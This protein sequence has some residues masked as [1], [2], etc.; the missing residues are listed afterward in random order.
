[1]KKNGG[2]CAGR[3]ALVTGASRGIGAAIA[4]R[5]ASEGAHVALAARS[6]DSAPEGVPGTLIEMTERIESRGGRA[7]AIQG[8]VSRAE[9][10]ERMASECENKLGP[11]EILVNN[12]AYGPYRPFSKFSAEDFERALGINMYA[13]LHLS[14]LVLP[15]MC[16]RRSGWIVNISSA[17]A[18]HPVGPPYI[19]WERIGGHHLYG[20]SK[21]GLDRLTAGM[22][23][24]FEEHG[25]AIN[26]LAPVAAVMTPGV[27]ASGV[28]K[29]IED[30]M[31]EPVEAMAEAALLLSTCDP[32]EI[33][34]RITY[35]VEFLEERGRAIRALDGTP[36]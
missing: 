10:R 22:A 33:T 19:A 14:Q 5:L 16:E 13:T 30:S 8:D 20:A 11:I 23:A 36:L 17:T 2:E 6:L 18:K 12:A 7:I 9:D 24:E 4:E 25:I 3:V 15:G 35:S 26:T 1:M 31:I 29:F 32:A 28:G 21:A 27:V 34:G